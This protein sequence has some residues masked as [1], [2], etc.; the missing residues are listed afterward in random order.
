MKMGN[1]GNILIVDDEPNAVKV[2]SSIL[3]D[4]GY[5]VRESLDVDGAVD[6]ILNNDI[7]AVITDLK[8]PGRDGMQFFEYVTKNHPDIP[9]IF[10]TAYGTVESAVSAMT[11]GAF[12]YFIKPPDYPKLKGI[13]ARAVEQRCLKKELESLRKRLMDGNS[14]YRIIGNTLTMRKIYETIEALKDSTSN[15]LILGETGTGKELIARCLH[16]SSKKKDRPFIPVNCSAI[17]RELMESELFG[18]EKGAFTGAFSKR[19][20]KFEEAGDG[21]IFLDEIGELE[22]SLQAKLL[23]VIQEREVERLGSNKKIKVQFRLISSTNRDLKD[24]VRTGNF[25]EDLYYRI[26]V[27]EVKVP[28]LRERKEDIPMIASEFVNEFCIREKKMLTVSNQVMRELQDYSWPGNVRQ[29]RNII[30]RAV[31]L[32]KGNSLTLEDLPG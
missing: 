3:S 14:R 11:R 20:G 18:Y 4:E 28:P 5:D 17:P 6:I 16:K 29:L 26:N 24:D 32:A 15:V 23:R 12:Y 31:V 8:M 30:E 1:N 9:V 7:D 2:L 25:R 22:L 19:I 27:V 10:L 13:L 21:I